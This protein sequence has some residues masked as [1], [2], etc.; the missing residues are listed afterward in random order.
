VS[1]PASADKRIAYTRPFSG[2][3]LP[4]HDLQLNTLGS[5]KQSREWHLTERPQANVLGGGDQ[6]ETRKHNLKSNAKRSHSLK[7]VKISL[8]QL[9]IIKIDACSL[10]F[11]SIHQDSP[12]ATK[13]T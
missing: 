6:A 12:R 13:Y 7:I 3:T 4:C 5:L 8:R 9:E 2:K 1:S 10:K 11:T